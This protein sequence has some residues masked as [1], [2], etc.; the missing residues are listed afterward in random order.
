MVN[1]LGFFVKQPVTGQ[2]KTRLG[3]SLGNET[4]AQLYEAILFDLRDR[5]AAIPN[6]RR[7]LAYAPDA[8]R[9]WAEK[10]ARS[11]GDSSDRSDVSDKS[12]VADSSPF[13][14]EQQI[15]GDL[16]QKMETFF[17][18]RFDE[19]TERVVIVGSDSPTLSAET[20]S[21]AF[22]L[23][24]ANDVVLG[25]TFDGG[26][27]LIGLSRPAPE[28]FREIA[29]STPAVFR[30]SVEAIATAGYRFGLLPAG[31]D[32]DEVQDLIL[33]KNDLRAMEVAGYVDKPELTPY[34][35][36]TAR[37]L[38]HMNSGSIE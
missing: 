18:R 13:E 2:V 11:V 22:E 12:R 10:V 29:W 19:G 1:V 31:Y 15:E 9:G 35:T 30:Q 17:L 26:Y 6:A 4:A 28:L 37:L 32:V 8:A 23:L 24:T 34:P 25:P 14:I 16:G 7:I 27:Y 20:I 36:R 5:L 38:E 21:A 3:R 33:L